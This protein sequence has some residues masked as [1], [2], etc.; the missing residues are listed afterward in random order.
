ME[1]ET[2]KVAPSFTV[3]EEVPDADKPERDEG[4]D[5]FEPCLTL[6]VRFLGFDEDVV[7]SLAVFDVPAIG[8]DKPRSLPRLATPTPQV[9]CVL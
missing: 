8:K 4:V 5:V 3:E 1:T 9:N 7:S 6:A 2:L